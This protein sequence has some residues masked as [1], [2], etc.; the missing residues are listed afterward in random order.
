MNKK[1]PSTTTEPRKRGRRP[2][3]SVSAPQRRAFTAIR[4]HLA[5]R[6]FP[7]TVQ[8]LGELL[9]L[10]TS[11]AHELVNQLVRK[12]YLRR[13]AGKARSLEIARQLEPEVADLVPVPIV[14]VVAGGR[15][16]YA[17]EN[18]VGEMLVEARLV[19]AA[20]C[21]ALE[22]SGDSMVGAGIDSGDYV[23]V[24]QQQVA[25]NG[26]IVVAVLGEDATVK[27]LY[28]ADER[29]ELRPEN[30]RHRPIVVGPDDGLRIQGKVIGVRK[31]A[32]VR[33]RLRDGETTRGA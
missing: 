17:V 9:G 31:L 20:R 32:E 29:I 10:G 28:I 23:V 4:N 7:P 8:E 25:E 19:G 30:P 33:S 1:K 15:P 5:H 26:D 3:A 21:F 16:I 24:R 11:S 6:G 2:V 22:V 18:F 13:D 27:R 14:G 12:G